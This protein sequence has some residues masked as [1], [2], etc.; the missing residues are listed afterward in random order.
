MLSGPYFVIRPACQP[1]SG[2]HSRVSM[3]SVK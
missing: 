2:V 1:W 3:W